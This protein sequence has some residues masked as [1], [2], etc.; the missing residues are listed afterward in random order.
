MLNYDVYRSSINRPHMYISSRLFSYLGAGVLPPSGKIGHNADY[1]RWLVDTWHSGEPQVRRYS[2]SYELGTPASLSDLASGLRWGHLHRGVQMLL[3]AS[4]T[5]RCIG[6]YPPLPAD[7]WWQAHLKIIIYTIIY[8]YIWHLYTYYTPIK[9]KIAF[10]KRQIHFLTRIG[11]SPNGLQV[12]HFGW[13]KITFDRIS[14]HFGSMCN[15]NFVLNFVHKMAAGCH[16]G[17]LKI[18]FDHISRHFRSIR[19]FYFFFTKWLAAAILDDRK[20]LLIALLATS[21]QNATLLFFSKWPSAA[22]LDDRKSLSITF[23]AISDQYSN[24]FFSQNGCRRPFWMTKNH[25]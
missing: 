8:I 1:S 24:F 2:P 9:I 25:F 16:F 14:R 5:P 21:D 20:S 18:T 3:S 17:W 19:N 13:P 11:V 12:G 6:E 7:Y 23:L 22:I 10:H 4:P 15:L